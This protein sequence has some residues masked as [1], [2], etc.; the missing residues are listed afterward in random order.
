MTNSYESDKGILVGLRLAAALTAASL[1][2]FASAAQE[3]SA[4]TRATRA[5][6]ASQSP[7]SAA[8][9]AAAEPLLRDYNVAYPRA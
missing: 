5:E 8:A 9:E 6:A 2:P 1:L 4:T 7:S 3:V